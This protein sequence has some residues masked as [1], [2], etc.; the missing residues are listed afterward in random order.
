MKKFEDRVWYERYSVGVVKGTLKKAS[1]DIQ[2]GAHVHAEKLEKKYGKKF[3]RWSEE[4]IDFDWGM[5][6]GKLSALRWVLGYDECD[7][8]DT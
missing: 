8:L 6:N 5:I 1:K 2:K 4:D 3:F 7:M